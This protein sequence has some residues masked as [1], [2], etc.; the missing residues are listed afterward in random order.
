MVQPKSKSPGEP[1]ER[2]AAQRVDVTWSVDCETPETFLYASIHN[3]SALGI[4]VHTTRP[5]PVGTSLVLR[6][7]PPRQPGFVLQGVVQWVNPF[8]KGHENLN[9][10]MGV[11]FVNLASDERERLVEIVKTIAYVRDEQ[12]SSN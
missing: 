11:R 12:S 9:P 8:R 2:R 1:D 4:F 7:A 6:F 5:L 3:I 10:G